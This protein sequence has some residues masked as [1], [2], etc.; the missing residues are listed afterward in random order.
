MEKYYVYLHRRATDGTVFYVG[1]GSGGRAWNSS[2]RN[3]HW[4]RVVDK[5]DYTVEIVMR[6]N[7]EDC[8]FSMEK[9]IISMYGIENLTNFE[10]GGRGKSG[11][12][13]N[14]L[15][16]ERI[17]LSKTGEKHPMYG[18]KHKPS[19]INAMKGTHVNTD[20]YT[21]IHPHE[22]EFIGN[23]SE[24]KSTF[25]LSDGD[26]NNLRA[27]VRT[28]RYNHF[29]GWSAKGISSPIAKPKGIGGK[30]NEV[31]SLIHRDGKKFTGTQA[32]HNAIYSV[33]A[34]CLL[35][36]GKAITRKGWRLAD[37]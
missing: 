3:A 5:H 24:L 20:V 22:G 33:Q 31:R 32:E 18:K 10:I 13:S 19:T 34:I 21:F 4:R 28:G 35:W 9:A 2:K 27:M 37:G 30:N 36:S 11:R 23:V 15:T 26:A 17:S 14:D 12:R 29:K 16:R 8:A 6:F 1:K 25:N 7:N